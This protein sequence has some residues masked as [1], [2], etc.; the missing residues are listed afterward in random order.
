MTVECVYGKRCVY[1][2]LLTV[3]PLVIF[4]RRTEK[5][6]LFF[7]GSSDMMGAEV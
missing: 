1:T 7:L 2:V 4:Y 3:P 6:V 5:Y